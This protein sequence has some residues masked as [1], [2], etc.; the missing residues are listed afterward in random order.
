[1]PPGVDQ[2]VDDVG[3]SRSVFAVRFKSVVGVAPLSDLTAWRM[4]LAQQVLQKGN[5]PVSQ[6]ADA[7]GYASVSAY[8]NAFKRVTGCV[9]KRFW[10]RFNDAGADSP[11]PGAQGRRAGGA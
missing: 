8:S 3:L 1:M 9:S 7:F 4:R 2:L 11:E 5:G 10:S 6:I